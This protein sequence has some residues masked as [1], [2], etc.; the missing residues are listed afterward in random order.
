MPRDNRNL[1]EVLKQELQFLERGGYEQVASHYWK[2]VSVFRNSPSCPNLDDPNRSVPCQECA[3]HELIPPHLRD[4]TVPCHF[5][6]LN[7]EGETI[8]SMERQYSQEELLEAVGMWLRTMIRKLERDNTHG[9]NQPGLLY[10]GRSAGQPR[11]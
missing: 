6:P 7:N 2:P 11:E 4:E 3:F 5:I 10:P 9:P 1:L 8:H